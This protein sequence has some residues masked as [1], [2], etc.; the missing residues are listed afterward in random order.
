MGQSTNGPDSADGGQ[1]RNRVA[2]V[3][4]HGALNH[5]GVLEHDVAAQHLLAHRLLQDP[6]DVALRATV[7]LELEGLGD[8]VLHL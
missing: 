1:R 3:E 6:G 8:G 4:R 2:R 7:V 5:D